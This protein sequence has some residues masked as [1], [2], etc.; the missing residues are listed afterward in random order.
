MS[1]PSDFLWGTATSAYQIEG[2]WDADG[3]GPSVWDAFCRQPGAIADGQS[4][5]VAC[6]HYRRFREDVELMAGLGMNAYRFSV[7]WPRV[8]PV[9]T[10][11]VNEA[12]LAFYERLVDALLEHGIR[13]FLTLY[14]WDTPLALHELG[15]WESPDAPAWFAEYAALVAGRLGDRVRD[16][17]TLNEPQVVA[18]HGYA[19][20]VHAPGIRDKAASLRVADG[21]MRAHDAA[22]EAVRATAPGA[23]VGIALNLMPCHPP[24]DEEATRMDDEVNRWYLDRAFATP[25]DFLGVNYYTRFLVGGPPP[26]AERTATGWEVYPPGMTEVLLRVHRDYGPP[27]IYVTENGAAYPDAVEDP[28]RIAYLADHIAAVADARDAGAPV[29]GYF[30]WSLLDNF[31]WATGFTK[32]FG[33]VR[34]DYGTQER[35][36]KASG[37]W[38]GRL[39]RG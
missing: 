23:R 1:F 26:H 8:L 31:E 9:G 22:A 3:K 15:G 27:S 37:R 34:V 33:I 18:S 6:D 38:Y 19:T 17:A 28:E 39:V 16:W 12:G 21:L 7:S 2:A 20:G 11:A 4:G 25:L 5:D 29:D 30:V 13:P 14:H 36:V 10:G 32:R 35:T 24:G